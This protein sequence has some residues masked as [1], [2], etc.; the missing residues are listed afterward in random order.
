MMSWLI[1][2]GFLLILTGIAAVHFWAHMRTIDAHTHAAGG[3]LRDAEY[4][5]PM[6][7]LL[8][9]YSNP[10]GNPAEQAEIRAERCSLFREYLRSLTW[11]YGHLLA[12]IRLAMA[13]S[14]VDRPDLI[15]ALLRNRILFAVA[16]C[17]IELRLTFYK[18]GICT[19][20]LLRTDVMGLMNAVN[21]LRPQPAM[22]AESA[23]WGA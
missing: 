18:R 23:V 4:Y 16:L 15:K 9:D 14:A 10:T 6:V 8:S 13:E 11:D 5:R 17:R 20:E 3:P 12:G 21:V 19:A 2:I 7:R 1:P 22:M